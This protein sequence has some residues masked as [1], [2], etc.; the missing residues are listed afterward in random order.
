M[1]KPIVGPKLVFRNI[2]NITMNAKTDESIKKDNST[3]KSESLG[4]TL[5]ENKSTIGMALLFLV[6]AILLFSQNESYKE[7]VFIAIT[8]AILLFAEGVG[9]LLFN[10]I[11]IAV[12]LTGFLFQLLYIVNDIVF[13]CRGNYLMYSDLFCANAAFPVMGEYL[14]T[15]RFSGTLAVSVGF[16]VALIL[17]TVIMHKFNLNKFD[18]KQQGRIRGIILAIATLAV[19]Y[20]VDLSPYKA[21]YYR[22]YELRDKYGLIGHLFVEMKASGIEEPAD[23]DQNVPKAY[24][25][26]ERLSTQSIEKY[27]NIFVIMDESFTDYSLIGELSTNK[28]PL[29]FLHSIENSHNQNQ[30]I[31]Y[32]KMYVP[33]WGGETANSE[34]E[35]LT[36]LSIRFCNNSIPYIQ[37]SSTTYPYSIVNNLSECGYET[38]AFQPYYSAGYNCRGVYENMG[39]NHSIFIEDIDDEYSNMTFN[40]RP[41]SEKIAHSDEGMYIREYV[42]DEYCFN[43][44]EQL[45]EKNKGN[46][47]LFFFNVTMQNHGP[48]NSTGF[49]SDV[50]LSEKVTD[51]DDWIN[52]FLSST[53][54]TDASIER[55]IEYFSNCDDPTIIVMFGDHHPYIEN[56]LYS[57]LFG[58]EDIASV[59]NEMKRHVTP[60]LLWANYDVD[61]SG[62]EEISSNF[63]ASQILK[64]AGVPQ[65]A[66]LKKNDELHED[67]KVFSR[68]GIKDTDGHIVTGKQPAEYEYNQYM[69]YLMTEQF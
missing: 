61:F 58:S 4:Q 66:W 7:P 30:S 57:Y 28:D 24:F 42:S 46:H 39:F 21:F 15:V 27:P 34:W 49:E 40:S 52:Q 20:V 19:L 31:L 65:N 16:I 33:S 63:L 54:R 35:F 41:S 51:N 22:F 10:D 67:F 44:M 11:S 26:K 43:Y 56:E 55:M 48:Y 45:Y 62:M 60:L 36:G 25:E 23:Y 12:C 14:G 29:P 5:Q 17:F 6:P 18:G 68:S 64:Y 8:M 59:E 37:F 50:I 3:K 2:Y 1:F 9:L 53:E 13:Q 38:W 69:Y 47:P 32:G